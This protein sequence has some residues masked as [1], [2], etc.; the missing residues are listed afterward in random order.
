MRSFF[1]MGFRNSFIPLMGQDDSGWGPGGPPVINLDQ[2]PATSNGWG[3]GGP[4]I[5]T[6][7]QQPTTP[8]V[9]P[10]AASS[11]GTDW[12]KLIAQ[13][14]TAAGAGY[15]AYSKEQIA[16][17]T[18]EAQKGKTPTGP[19]M[20]PSSQGAGISSNTIFLVGGLAVTALIAVVA[21]K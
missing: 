21:L 10:P 6:L 12:A 20:A 5:T 3:P 14:I 7:N 8:S 11:G 9:T 15:S 16:K 2:Q 13:G 18:A 17:L 19:I 4:P 1:Q